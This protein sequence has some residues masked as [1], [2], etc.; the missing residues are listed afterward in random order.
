[1]IHQ[2]AVIIMTIVKEAM[3]IY[4]DKSPIIQITC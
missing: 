3:E 1:M 4:S 2:D